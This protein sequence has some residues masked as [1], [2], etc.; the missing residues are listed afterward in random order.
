M[1]KSKLLK[2]LTGQELKEKYEA[3]KLWVINNSQEVGTDKN[4]LGEPY[5]NDK[6][7]AGLK[8]LE[9]IEDELREKGTIL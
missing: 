9:E 5:N 6:F 8:R 4:V 3:G 2:E 7:V 1:E